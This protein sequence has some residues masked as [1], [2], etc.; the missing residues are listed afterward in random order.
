MHVNHV[1][2]DVGDIIQQ[3]DVSPDRDVAMIPRRRRQ[4]ARE[5]AGN[6]VYAPAEVWSERLSRLKTRFLGGREPIL[7][8]EARRRTVLVLTVP[9]A[10]GLTGVVIEL[11]RPLASLIRPIGWS[12]LC[13]DG[14]RRRNQSQR[15]RCRTES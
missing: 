2:Q 6:R 3:A 15:T 8:S 12:S 5:I 7:G 4:L 1:A 14:R 11:H 10:R 13:L 9:I